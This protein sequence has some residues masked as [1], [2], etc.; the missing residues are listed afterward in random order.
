MHSYAKGLVVD[1]IMRCNDELDGRIEQAQHIVAE[2]EALLSS[3]QFR[4]TML[5]T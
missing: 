3:Q 5:F 4:R 1:E 2:A